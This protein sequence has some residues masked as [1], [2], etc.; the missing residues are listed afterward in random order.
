MTLC[1]CVSSVFDTDA[2]LEAVESGCD[3]EEQ[4]LCKG[5][6][7]AQIN[8]VDLPPACMCVRQ[9]GADAYD[10][11]LFKHVFRP[12]MTHV[13]CANCFMVNRALFRFKH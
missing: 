8:T 12:P 9:P 3:G 5:E 11:S 1:V 6:D 4:T 13:I 10:S 2:K 7:R